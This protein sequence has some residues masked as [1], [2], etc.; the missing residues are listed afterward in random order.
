MDAVGD[1]AKQTLVSSCSPGRV[2]E[3]PVSFVAESA[4]S[5]V[6]TDRTLGNRAQRADVRNVGGSRV[7]EIVVI[8]NAHLAGCQ[9]GTNLTV[10]NRALKARYCGAGVWIQ[11]IIIGLVTYR[12]FC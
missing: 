8:S 6:S 9:A 5:E 2:K 11:E 1:R 10:R 12:A 7:Q 4:E 3:V